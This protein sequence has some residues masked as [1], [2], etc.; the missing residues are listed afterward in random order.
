MNNGY[1]NNSYNREENSGMNTE[2]A[3]QGNTQGDNAQNNGQF[4]EQQQYN[5]GFGYQNP[6][7]NGYQPPYGYPDESGLFSENKMSRLNGRSA[8]MKITDWLKYDCLSLLCLIPIFGSIAYLVIYIVLLCSDKTNK[9]LKSRMLASLIW[10]GIAV[11]I[12]VI[13]F[14]LLI[15]IGMFGA[16]GGHA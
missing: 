7:G 6:Y 15:S 8:T 11:A 2:S 5:N 14:V 1:D 4:Y 16:L 3:Q 9:C 13:V 10:T 12:W